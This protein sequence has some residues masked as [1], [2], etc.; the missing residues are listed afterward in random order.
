MTHFLPAIIVFGILVTIHEWG[1]FIVAKR[2]G[3]CVEVFSIG[4]GPRIFKYRWH[5]T[6]YVVSIIPLG[7]YVKMAGD[8][9]SQAKENQKEHDFFAKTPWQRMKVAMAGP[10]MNYLLAYVI[11][12][13]IFFVGSSV[14]TSK[15]GEVIQKTPADL[16]GLK[17]GDTIT[18]VNGNA[19]KRWDEVRTFFRQALK[20]D[21]NINLGF[22]RDSQEESVLIPKKSLSRKDIIGLKPSKEVINI[23]YP[24]FKSLGLGFSKLWYLSSMTYKSLWHIV[25]GKISLK[26]SMTGPVGII[27]I[28]GKTAEKGL[29]H[30][31]H[32]MAVL[33]AALALFNFLPIPALD[34]GHFF[35]YLLEILIRRPISYRLQYIFNGI[36]MTFLLGLMAFIIYNDCVNFSIGSKIKGLWQKRF[37]T[38]SVE[39]NS[40]SRKKTS[41]LDK[42]TGE[43]L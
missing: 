7:G 23:K 2:Q 10:L 13:A 37:S 6:L 39:E 42:R 33:S 31:L 3:I 17:Q 1:H 27:L 40:S 32:L 19:V 41:A 9:P 25:V 12:A 36:G 34:G 24:F 38:V 18:S 8:D 16:A 21:T 22:L 4:F 29:I 11:F 43:V 28:T 15:I 20:E 5:D 26:E 30:V 35:L 14:P